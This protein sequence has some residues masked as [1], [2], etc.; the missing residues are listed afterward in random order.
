MKVLYFLQVFA[1]Y[2]TGSLNT[3]LSTEHRY[4]IC[5]YIYNHQAW[6]LKLSYFVVNVFGWTSSIFSTGKHN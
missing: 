4:E 2:V 3:V 1:L 5:R 6:Q